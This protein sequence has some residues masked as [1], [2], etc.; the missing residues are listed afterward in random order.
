MRL[1]NNG[2]QKMRNLTKEQIKERITKKLVNGGWNIETVK[3]MINDNF[4]YAYETYSTI[5]CMTEAITI[6]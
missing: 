1:R 6:L 2:E 3:E 4:E 5:K